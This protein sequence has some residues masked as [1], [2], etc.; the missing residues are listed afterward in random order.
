MAVKDTLTPRRFKKL[1]AT[2]SMIDIAKKY[3]VSKQYISQLYSEYKEQHPKLFAES[4]IS[5][6]WLTEML[7]THTIKEIC[8]ITGKSYHHIRKFM[9]EHEIEQPTASANFDRDYIYEQYVILCKSDEAI[10]KHYSCSAS[11][12]KKF[13]NAQ[14]ILY[15][16]RVPLSERLT[17]QLA[18]TLICEGKTIEQLSKQFDATPYK[19]RRLLISYDLLPQ[20]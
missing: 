15:E 8:E 17:R 18:T 2:H 5:V 19:I 20:A 1:L 4:A 12:V 7:T 11:L 14:G 6:E 13:R 16:D 3:G 10:A 9:T